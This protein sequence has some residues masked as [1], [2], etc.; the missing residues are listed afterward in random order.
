MSENAVRND[1]KDS[2]TTDVLIS[3]RKIIQSIAMNSRSL[4]KRIG[5]T[6]PQLLA[7]Q[8]VTY[9]ENLMKSFLQ[10]AEKI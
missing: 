7:L 8:E 9:P 2:L 6:G 10:H 5:L 1:L 3:I 4:V